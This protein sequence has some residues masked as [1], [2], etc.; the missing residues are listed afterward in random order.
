MLALPLF[1]VGVERTDS[2][3]QEP[4]LSPLPP[5]PD[6]QPGAHFLGFRL[7]LKVHISLGLDL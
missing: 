4:K 6:P 5:T 2:L 1:P 7:E 3:S